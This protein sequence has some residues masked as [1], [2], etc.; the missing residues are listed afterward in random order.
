LP[1]RAAS[2]PT[3]LALSVGL[4]LA[5]S[6]ALQGA[7]PGHL[8]LLSTAGLL[9]GVGVITRSQVTLPGVLAVGVLLRVVMI[10]MPPT[11]SDDIWRYVWDGLVQANG[12][13]PYLWTPTLRADLDTGE[14]LSRLNSPNFYSVYPPLSQMLFFPAGLVTRATGEAWLGVYAIKI[15]LGLAE[16]AALLLLSRM[17]PA[18]ALVLYAWNPLV[19]IEVA[20][21]HTELLMLPFLVGTCAAVRTERLKLAGVLLAGA[22]LVKLYPVLLWPLLWRRGGRRAIWPFVVVCFLAAL[23]YLHPDVPGRV[24][25]SLRLYTS[26]FEFHAQPYFMLRDWVN[27]NDPSPANVGRAVAG[28][29]LQ[30]VLLAGVLLVILIDW[31]RRWPFE[32]SVAIV[33]ALVIVTATTVHPWYLL[34]LLAIPAILVRPWWAWLIFGWLT[35]GTY[36]RYLP[37]GEA[38]YLA[39]SEFAWTALVAGLI[40]QG[41][42]PLDR[43]MRFRGRM[44]ASRVWRV[45]GVRPGSLVLDLGCGE[46]HVGADLARRGAAVTLADVEAFGIRRDLPFVRYDGRRLPF[47][48]ATF[49]AV[50]LVYV[51]HHSADA[52]AT[53]AEAL[54]VGKR[55]VVVESVYCSEAGRRV[56]WTLDVLA[57]RLRGGS[58][59]AG[60]EEHLHFR[61]ASEWVE[62]AERLGAVVERLEEHGNPPHRQATLV[63]HLQQHL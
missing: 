40:L 31:L 18:R 44:K 59:M 57:N 6:L 5:G 50:A 45:G 16:L 60:Q 19:L 52:E 47:A 39:W 3:L 53:L 22:T 62:V 14:L 51:L 12:H 37:G 34:G 35:L 2:L 29:W 25:D 42:R 27:V 55:V 43:V 10:A 41:L 54:R 9:V 61:R 46:G 58:V 23:P 38:A 7:W 56:L 49:D 20:Q 28:V 17:L 26:Y 4:A 32:R 8:L 21:G 13:N 15:P 1:Q 24:S 63:L 33:L 11:L 36:V 30:R 48:D